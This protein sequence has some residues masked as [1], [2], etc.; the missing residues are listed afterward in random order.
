MS[1]PTNRIDAVFTPSAKQSKG[2]AFVGFVTAGDPTLEQTPDLMSALA[3]GGADIIE[4]G[5]PF[6]DPI[7]DGPVIQRS[8]QRALKK[9]TDLAG[10]LEAVRVFRRTRSTA[11]LLF[12]YFNPFLSY[13]LAKLVA[14]AHAAGVDGFLVVDLPPEEAGEFKALLDEKGMRLIFLVSP[15]T[16]D[17]RI[18]SIVSNASGF[19]YYVAIKGV[20]GSELSDHTDVAAGVGR[21]KAHTDLPV[22][23]GFGISSP[24]DSASIGAVAD[25]VVVGSAIVWRIEGRGADMC[26]RVREFVTGLKEPLRPRPSDTP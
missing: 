22:C 9:G 19:I 17:A 11:V 14:D 16:S 3:Q 12:G 8:S 2:T 25:G 6:S 13:G 20:T 7:A 15:N 23:V 5:V 21:V 4:L 18:E 26:D 24:E 10:I 1:E